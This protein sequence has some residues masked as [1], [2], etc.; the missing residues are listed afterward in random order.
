MSSNSKEVFGSGFWGEM[1]G[2]WTP[3]LLIGLVTGIRLMGTIMYWEVAAHSIVVCKGW[4][5]GA[6]LTTNFLRD[7]AVNYLICAHAKGIR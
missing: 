7:E 3:H 5:L 2:Q 4:V 6:R 1:L